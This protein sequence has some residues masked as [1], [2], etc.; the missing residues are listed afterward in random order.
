MCISLHTMHIICKY[1]YTWISDTIYFQSY[2]VAVLCLL[3]LLVSW[4]VRN[5][6]SWSYF[7][8]FWW[9]LMP[10]M[11]C[12]PT[13]TVHNMRLFLYRKKKWQMY[14]SIL[15]HLPVYILINHN[16]KMSFMTCQNKPV[17]IWAASWQNQQ[18]EC[19]P[20][21]DSDQ[22]G[23]LP[24]LIRVFAV[25][26]VGSLGPKLSSCGQRKLSSLGAHSFCWFCYVAAH[27]FTVAVLQLNTVKIIT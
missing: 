21:E 9:R 8:I 11:Y 20:S 25:R 22:P 5:T 26:S 23:H 17:T 10:R 16:E 18:N 4:M 2:D 3:F 12:I 13:D 15:F 6:W 27:L 14:F 1:E 7:A 19:A 24:S